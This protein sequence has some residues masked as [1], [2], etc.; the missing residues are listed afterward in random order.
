MI[1]RPPR[2]TRTDTL[3]PYT[4]LFRSWKQW[5]HGH[6]DAGTSWEGALPDIWSG[7]FWRSRP[8]IPQ[9]WETRMINRMKRSALGLAY[10]VSMAAAVFGGH[11]ALAPEKI[12]RAWG[13]RRVGQYVYI[14][15]G[16]V[17]FTKKTIP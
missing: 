14:S 1:L 6:S 2:S 17:A 5:Q 3:F 4:T 7:A 15:V 12:G 9:R 13:R 8:P 16:A 11:Q 10:A